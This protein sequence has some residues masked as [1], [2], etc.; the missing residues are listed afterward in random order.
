[1]RGAEAIWDRPSIGCENAKRCR[2]S[3][4]WPYSR[5]AGGGRPIGSA[6]SRRHAVNEGLS[7]R[8]LVGAEPIT[9]LAVRYFGVRAYCAVSALADWSGANCDRRFAWGPKLGNVLA[10]PQHA[11]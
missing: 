1:M 7:D 11:G 2:A 5:T 9:G 6:P 8:N 4:R 3:E 10:V